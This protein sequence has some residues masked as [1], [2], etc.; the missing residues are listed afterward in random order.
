MIDETAGSVFRGIYG[1][2]EFPDALEEI[3]TEVKRRHDRISPGGLTADGYA[4][5][6]FLADKTSG[7]TKKRAKKTEPAPEPEPE[8][9]EGLGV[10]GKE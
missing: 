2:N 3:Y 9:D 10:D 4:I 1:E 7:P 8:S 6:S 5:V